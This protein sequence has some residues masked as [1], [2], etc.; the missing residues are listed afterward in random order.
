MFRGKEYNQTNVATW[1]S[2]VNEECI[3]NLT[4]LNKNFKYIVKTIVI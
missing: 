1:I 2:Q 3:K 4:T